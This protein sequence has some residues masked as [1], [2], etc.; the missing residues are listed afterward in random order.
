MKHIGP[1]MS[2]Q[3]TER[4][5]QRHQRLFP[6][7]HLVQICLGGGK[8]TERVGRRDE[9]ISFLGLSQKQTQIS[10]SRSKNCPADKRIVNLFEG[11]CFVL[12]LVFRIQISEG[13]I[14]H[15]YAPQHR[16]W[17]SLC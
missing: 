2:M 14:L 4:R 7:W 9:E 8:E 15:Y 17:L 5:P 11:H 3:R 10:H 6:S 13:R 16:R 1:Q 12:C